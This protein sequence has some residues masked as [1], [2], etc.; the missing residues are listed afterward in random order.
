MPLPR[1]CQGLLWSLWASWHCVY[2]ISSLTPALHIWQIDVNACVISVMH[3]TSK[4]TRLQYPY[5]QT[6]LIGHFWSYLHI[7]MSLYDIFK[8]LSVWQMASSFLISCRKHPS[9]FCTKYSIPDMHFTWVAL[10]R[11]ESRDFLL[12]LCYSNSGDWLSS[13]IAIIIHGDGLGVCVLSKLL[14]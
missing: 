12:W 14:Q 4:S 6:A 13:T 9:W 8:Q 3:S 2:S 5:Y 1:V 10:C 11:T 7:A